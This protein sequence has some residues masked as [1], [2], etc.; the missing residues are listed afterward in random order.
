MFRFVRALIFFQGAIL[1][2]CEAAAP[3]KPEET[4]QAA[5]NVLCQLSN[6]ENVCDTEPTAEDWLAFVEETQ[7][8]WTARKPQQERWEA[9]QTLDWVAENEELVWARLKTL[10]MVDAVLPK[11]PAP[12]A[13]CILGSTGPSMQARIRFAQSRFPNVK[14][15][16]LLTGERAAVA[17]VDGDAATLQAVSRNAQVLVEDLQEKH[18]MLEEWRKTHWPVSGLVVCLNTPKGELP[19]ATTET[20]LGTLAAWLAR[21]P[22]IKNVTFVSNQ[23]Y[24]G[25]QKAVIRGVLCR[26]SSKTVFEVVGPE[27]KT[28]NARSA[29]GA[30]GSKIWAKTPLFLLKTYGIGAFNEHF[31]KI[32]GSQ[33]GFTSLVKSAHQTASVNE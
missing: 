6:V 27:M 22:H 16:I 5:L 24:V 32:Y 30:L 29:V 12:D 7:R 11:S 28:R 19:R 31:Y 18:L 9:A 10:K 26:L 33:P 17:N 20:T 8:V 13:V 1:V 14:T 21:N 4:K 15:W 2:A 23:P 3:A 25:Y